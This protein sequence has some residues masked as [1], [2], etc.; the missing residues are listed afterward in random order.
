MNNK[1][2]ENLDRPK[3]EQKRSMIPTKILD[4]IRIG[5]SLQMH[6]SVL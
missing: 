5:K 4:Q 1:S 2:G 6:K 3:Q